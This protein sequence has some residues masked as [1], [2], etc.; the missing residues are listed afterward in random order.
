MSIIEV[1]EDFEAYVSGELSESA[2]RDVLCDTLRAE[3][4]LTSA[5]IAMAATLRRGKVIGTELEAAIL[6]DISDKSRRSSNMPAAQSESQDLMA[7]TVFKVR[8]AAPSAER[9]PVARRD[10]KVYPTL[11]D[12]SALDSESAASDEPSQASPITTT[13]SRTGSATGS[14][15]DTPERLAEPAEPLSVG[16]VLDERY[17]LVEELGHG[18]M[19]VVY[20]ALDRTTAEFKDRNPYVAIKLLNEEFK[21]HPLAVRSLQREA[22]KAQK[23]AHPNIV[24]VYHFARDGGNVYMVMEL[25]IGQS[26]DQLQ[27]RQYR[28]GMPVKKVNEFL[29]AMAAGLGYA[30]EQ[31][32]VH[33]DFKPS[34]VFVA[35]KG[36]I[37]VLDFGVA[38]A[39]RTLN[40][41]GDKTI[42]DAG[43]L[44]A[45]SPPYASVEMLT[46]QA[47][48][49]RDDIY[50][51]ACVTYLL[52]SGHHPFN[53]IDAV[54]ARLAGLQPTPIKS[55]SRSQWQ[56]LKRALAFERAERTASVNEFVAQFSV[57]H[58][59]KSWWPITAA[60]ATVALLVIILGQQGW[61]A[62]LG[63]KFAALQTSDPHAFSVAMATLQ[64][65]PESWQRRAMLDDSVRKSVLD[66]YDAAVRA[67]ELAPDYNFVYARQLV[68]QLKRLLPDSQVVARMAERLD[69]DAKLA[70]A[71]QLGKRD[72]ALAQGILVPEQGADSLSEV[73]A[74]IRRIDPSQPALSDSTLPAVFLSAA[75]NASD[76]G[77]VGLAES[78]V[79]ARLKFVPTDAT[80]TLTQTQP[81]A[82][83]DSP[84]RATA[85]E[86]AAVLGAEGAQ[87]LEPANRLPDTAPTTTETVSPD[88]LAKREELARL[89][90]KPEASQRWADQ[91]RAVLQSLAN[92]MPAGDSL[93]E[94]A[95]HTADVTF[96][97]AAADA[98]A[99][100]QPAEAANLV[101]IGRTVNPQSLDLPRDA[102]ATSDQAASA[103]AVANAEQRAG[104]DVLKL[105]I[106]EQA[107]AGDVAG[108]NTNAGVLRRV[109]AGG[110]YVSNELPKKIM[111]SYAQLARKQLLAGSPDAALK[112]IAAGRK[113]FGTSPDLKNLE[114]RYITVGDA[115]DRLSIAVVLN[116]TEQ[117]QY[118]DQ[119]RANEGM[120]APDIEKML[121]RT[122]ADR[123][124]DQR[125]ANRPSVVASLLDAGHKVFPDYA[126]LEQGTP[127]ALS[128]EPIEVVEQ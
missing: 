99:R 127:G 27:R 28:G 118:I 76:A 126:G 98:R 123:I 53:R 52:L 67:A 78:L 57:R 88:M 1:R 81:R 25:L 49:P 64:A 96:A 82:S 124:A 90:A 60:I 30:H 108:V 40:D 20:K 94:Q 84:E 110:S 21:R 39:A 114:L 113:K 24:S 102:G 14:A 70:L 10:G 46:G 73:L 31:G 36:V 37:K 8:P 128:A 4:E 62:Y 63:A 17:E 74:R 59:T 86:H 120:D 101:A 16:S 61:S 95:R 11:G 42:F 15:W 19:G 55:V 47:P 105:K 6:A 54:K 44:G 48:D 100:Q 13:G 103:A 122:L 38:R 87:T 18:G 91:L 29:N 51:L 12:I 7:R 125:A 77:Q 65:A 71:A 112:T 80:Q 83:L 41:Q 45:I 117:Q 9:D 68:G 66:H 104:I 121:A 43:Q 34:N 109:L 92:S 89:L 116:V 75:K 23:L 119:I 115:Y 97:K 3:P 107:D 106:D 33:A 5:C 79:Q 2:L 26:L 22:R 35:A 50:A 69:S 32:I 72:S 93:L 85:S 56:A 58:R 111:R